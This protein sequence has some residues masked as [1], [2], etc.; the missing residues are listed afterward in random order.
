MI[1][2]SIEYP[3]TKNKGRESF[4]TNP[5]II[6]T[7]VRLHE[8]FMFRSGILLSVLYLVKVVWVRKSCFI[9]IW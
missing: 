2:Y 1:P 3:L 4:L 8:K 9:L 7:K 5:S 6:F